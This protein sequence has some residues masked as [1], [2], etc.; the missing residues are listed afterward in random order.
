MRPASLGS[1][2]WH[3]TFAQLTR[4]HQRR[5][6]AAV[7]SNPWRSPAPRVLDSA[8][9]L[10]SRSRCAACK[11]ENYSCLQGPSTTQLTKEVRSLQIGKYPSASRALHETHTS[12]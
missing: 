2:A 5:L 9:S 7:I 1:T 3:A 11:Q 6:C 10:A 8:P 4:L 12:C